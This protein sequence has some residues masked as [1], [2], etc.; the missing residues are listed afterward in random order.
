MLQHVP[1]PLVDIGANLAH[2]SFAKDVDQVVEYARIEA[3]MQHAV[4]T[5]SSLRMLETNL[6]ICRRHGFTCT[7]GIHPHNAEREFLDPLVFRSEMMRLLRQ[8]D[9]SAAI[10]AVGETGLDYFRMFGSAEAQKACFEAHVALACELG[11]P[12]F[13]HEREAHVDFLEILDKFLIH[14]DQSNNKS[15]P[16]PAVVHCFTGTSAEAQ[17]YVDRGFYIGIT[18]YVGMK[19]RGKRLREDVLRRGVIPLERLMVETDCPYMVPD[20]CAHRLMQERRN[21]PVT[22]MDT[23]EVLARELNVSYEEVARAT[24]AN[25]R[26]FFRLSVSI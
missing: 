4:L 12:L 13:L 23:V 6:S 11:M 19:K 16:V 20:G 21:E 3:G 14:D 7:L 9:S 22:L 24:T 15:L 2:T 25:A 26:S 10:V 18:G 1:L 5:T 8:Q 17:A